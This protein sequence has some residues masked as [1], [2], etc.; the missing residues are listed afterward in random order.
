VRTYTN[1]EADRVRLVETQFIDD[2]YDGND[3]AALKHFA[4]L[5]KKNKLQRIALHVT[6]GFTA[7]ML[8]FLLDRDIKFQEV[9]IFSASS[10]TIKRHALRKRKAFLQITHGIPAP[11]LSRYPTVPTKYEARIYDNGGDID[12]QELEHIRYL[13]EAEETLLEFYENAIIEFQKGVLGAQGR[14]PDLELFQDKLLH[15]T[16]ETLSKPAIDGNAKI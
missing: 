12:W 16:A 11:L 10:R 3:N 13:Q 7:E 14:N 4:R 15:R 8:L 1:W 5:C 2:E 9:S 6:E